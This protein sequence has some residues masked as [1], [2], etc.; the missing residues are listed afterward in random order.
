M[1]MTNAEQPAPG[2]VYSLP[3]IPPPPGSTL[4]V[5]GENR[6]GWTPPPMPINLPPD[7]TL[8]VR[9]G[10][11]NDPDEKRRPTDPVGL[12][13]SL[14]K[15]LLQ[16]PERVVRLQCVGSTA[17][18]IASEAFRLAAADFEQRQHGFVL[19]NRQ[20]TYTANVGGR[21]AKGICLR[22]FPIPVRDA[23]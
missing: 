14:L 19:V 6:V 11:P 9:G 10:N 12:S 2:V 4:S 15:V 13:R 18:Y 16:N 1:T 23:L 5:D 7:C 22:V 17:L 20:S 3:S 21:N 8:R